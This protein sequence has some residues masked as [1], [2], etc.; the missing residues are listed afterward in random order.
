MSR[1][2][3]GDTPQNPW[4]LAR[5][6]GGHGGAPELMEAFR[7]HSARKAQPRRARVR[8]PVREEQGGAM[9]MHCSLSSFCTDSCD[10]LTG[11]RELYTDP[12]AAVPIK[13]WKAIGTVKNTHLGRMSGYVTEVRYCTSR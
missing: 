8:S 5:G 11:E 1:A 4:P 9:L 6:H 10:G 13:R 12:G 2:P 7:T 3:G